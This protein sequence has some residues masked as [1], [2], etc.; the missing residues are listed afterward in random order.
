MSAKTFAVD[1]SSVSRRIKKWFAVDGSGITRKLKKAWVIDGSGIARQIFS[2]EDDLVMISA[3]NAND[4]GFAAGGFGSVTPNVLGDG[5]VI[6]EILLSNHTAPNPDF[7]QLFLLGIPSGGANVLAS[8]LT[9]ITV[10]GITLVPS[11]ANFSFTGGVGTGN[12]GWSN[13]RFLFPGG[14]A[15]VPVVVVRS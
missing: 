13:Q 7:F 15:T 8:Y 10:N 5:S 9:S 11:G 6:D 1:G 2:A 14:G 3:T 12:W 4:F